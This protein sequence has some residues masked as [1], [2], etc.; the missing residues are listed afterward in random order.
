MTC[1]DAML[2]ILQRQTE[3]LMY[4]DEMTD[5]YAFLNLSVLKDVHKKQTKEEL[6]NLRKAKCNFIATFGMLPVYNATDPRIIP[7]EWKDKTTSDVDE[8]SLK[9]LIKSSLNNYLNWEE[10]TCDIYKSAAMVFKDN[11]NFPLYRHTCDLI[12]EVQCEIQKV[13][14]L[15][16][17]AVTC[18]YHP[19]YFK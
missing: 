11:M 8:Q 15:M 9:I 4:H 14:D 2:T 18:G 5:Y 7:V 13:K 1:K 16:L 6:C 3:G 19:T 12:E 10:R 17:E